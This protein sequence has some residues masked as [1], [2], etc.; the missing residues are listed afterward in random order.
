MGH[1]IILHLENEEYDYKYNISDLCF[2]LAGTEFIRTH[3]SYVVN[4]KYIE[5]ITRNECQ[6]IGNKKVPLS[7]NSYKSVNEKF[8]NYYKGKGV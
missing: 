4:I 1:Y 3:R 2:D 6:L 7:R 5:K 8:I